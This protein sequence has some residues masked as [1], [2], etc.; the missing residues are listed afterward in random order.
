MDGFMDKCLT[1]E[2]DIIYRMGATILDLWR[3]CD[4]RRTPND[5]AKLMSNENTNTEYG[6][7]MIIEMLD[8]LE[9]RK[10]ITYANEVV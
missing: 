4:G 9:T 10:L 8:L 6:S 2:D 5:L 3:K 7:A 1:N